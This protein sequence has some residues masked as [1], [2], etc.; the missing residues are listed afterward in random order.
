MLKGLSAIVTG[1]T[2]GIGLEI[3]RRLTNAGAN[4]VLNGFGDRKI[5]DEICQELEKTSGSRVIYDGADLAKP[6]EI[7]SLVQRTN[8]Q[9]G[10]VDILVNNAGIQHTSPIE[11]F[12]L[13]QW[14]QIID[15]NLT[16]PFLLTKVREKSQKNG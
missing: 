9:F 10:A 13:V 14:Q 2:S 3:A 6:A 7:S 11:N 4:L 16:A 5:V 1:S 8:E 15:I 12:H